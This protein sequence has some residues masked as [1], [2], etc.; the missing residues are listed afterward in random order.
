MVHMPENADLAAAG[1]VNSVAL[2]GPVSDPRARSR[3]S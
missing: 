1:E 2:G 3:Q